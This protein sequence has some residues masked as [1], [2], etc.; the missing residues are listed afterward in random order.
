ML[1]GVLGF[2]VLV[3]PVPARVIQ[4]CTVFRFQ[5]LCNG[6]SSLELAGIPDLVRFVSGLEVV[7]P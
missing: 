4:F 2:G 1:G 5:S 3:A 6:E 7:Q